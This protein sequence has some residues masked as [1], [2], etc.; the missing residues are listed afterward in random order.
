MNDVILIVGTA[1]PSFLAGFGIREVVE[2]LTKKSK[3]KT[4]IKFQNQM[5][6]LPQ[7]WTRETGEIGTMMELYD[8]VLFSIAR[9]FDKKETRNRLIKFLEKALEVWKTDE[10]Y[11]LL[12]ADKS[13]KLE[14]LNIESIN[15]PLSN[16]TKLVLEKRLKVEN[17]QA[18]A[19][20]CLVELTN[21]K[22]PK[23]VF[24]VFRK[25]YKD[26]REGFYE[27]ILSASSKV[28]AALIKEK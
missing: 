16:W 19:R 24:F 22:N 6:K 18:L 3:K 17:N 12:L 8:Q 27:E 5:N 7:R 26:D 13:V 21:H 11:L 14:D 2:L 9:W 23:D 15:T 10:S 20:D 4:I 1:V 25:K 28:R